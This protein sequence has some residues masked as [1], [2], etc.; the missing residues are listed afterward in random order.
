MKQ[1]PRCWFHKLK[2]RLGI[3][4]YTQ[5]DADEALFT[6]C[7]LDGQLSYVCVHVDDMLIMHNNKDTVLMI[8]ASL[9]QICE[10]TDCGRSHEYLGV[11]I[12]HVKSGIFIHQS[13][14]TMGIIKK[15]LQY[16]NMH[17]STP[18]A[19]KV[20]LHSLTYSRPT[21]NS[22]K[23][24]FD[25]PKL[26]ASCTG[27]L[28]YLSNFTR[29]DITHAV[30]QLCKYNKSPSYAHWKAAQHILAYLYHTYDFGLLYKRGSSPECIGHCDASFCCD[31]D[32]SRSIS[33]YCFSMSG[34]LIN[35]RSK[36][37][38]TV[39]CSTAEAEYL[40]INDTGKF[41]V[42]MKFLL[43]ELRVSNT[44]I[45]VIVGENDP[46]MALEPGTKGENPVLIYS[47]NASALAMVH[48]NH[49]TRNMKHVDKWHH[50]AREKTEEGLLE[51]KHVPG[52]N[53]VAD[54]LT[55]FL[56]RDPFLQYR[57][58]MGLMSWS[59]LK[60]EVLALD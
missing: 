14:Y 27:S 20:V 30:N 19:P 49:T 22:A 47:D 4:G 48:N 25:D 17:A 9:S 59:V 35:W 24:A 45:P 56:P 26:Y 31:V 44:T 6:R 18:M 28:Q 23:T 54:A 60:D 34:A 32:N 37:Q 13:S 11:T 5:S 10:I 55:K 12:E 1:A 8:V 52:K 7:E 39:T 41:G 15:F 40:A 2:E 50:W 42:H 46:P 53:N 58:Q 16:E 38:K 33:G 43:K 21:D 51:F 36:Q 3:L 29:P 57:E